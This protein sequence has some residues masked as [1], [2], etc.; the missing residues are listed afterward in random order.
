[1]G[2]DMSQFAY[3][4]RLCC[5]A[6]LSPSSNESAGKKKSVRIS[7]AG[8]YLKPTLVQCAHAAVKKQK[9]KIPI[10]V[11]STSVFTNDVVRSVPS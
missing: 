4:K 8:V 5:W 1:M 9:K 7:R 6:G 10:T 11:Q 3:S 2:V